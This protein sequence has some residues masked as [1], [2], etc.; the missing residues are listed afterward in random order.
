MFV[1]FADCDV[2]HMDVAEFKK[3]L[4]SYE[5]TTLP[6]RLDEVFGKNGAI[7]EDKMGQMKLL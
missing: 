5:F 7:A 1:D 3:V 2:K 4:L 6:K